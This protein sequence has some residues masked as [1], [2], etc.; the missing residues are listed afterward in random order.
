M[1]GVRELILKEKSEWFKVLEGFH[2]GLLEG[3]RIETSRR[4]VGSL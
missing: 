3:A 1:A 2:P 4:N